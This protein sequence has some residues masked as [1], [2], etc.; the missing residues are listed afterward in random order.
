[1]VSGPEALTVAKGRATPTSQ[2]TRYIAL[3]L[4]PAKALV[5]NIRSH[6]VSIGSIPVAALDFIDRQNNTQ[7]GSAVSTP[8]ARTA[9]PT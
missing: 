4:K 7:Y 9:T 8:P 2:A 1:V 6:N 3:F 5:L